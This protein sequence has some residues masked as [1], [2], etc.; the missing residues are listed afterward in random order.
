[1]SSAPPLSSGRPARTKEPTRWMM[2]RSMRPTFIDQYL[3][4]VKQL[5]KALSCDPTA[6]TNRMAFRN[7]IDRIVVQPADA[8]REY[9]VFTYGR[10][11]AIMGVDLSPPTRTN[12]EIFREEGVTR[13][14]IGNAD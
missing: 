4:K 1:M 10:L 5:D 9:E 11:S 6:P 13:D 3:D 2:S 14:Y 12:K 8:G 7:V